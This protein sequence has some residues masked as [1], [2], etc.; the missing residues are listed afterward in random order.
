MGDRVIDNPIIN[1]PYEA[2][3]RYFDFDRD[4]IT[5]RVLDGR[6]PSSF[7]IP[8]PRP[9]KRGGQMELTVFTQDDITQNRQVNEV[10]LRDGCR[11]ASGRPAADPHGPDERG[12]RHGRHAA[13][14]DRHGQPLYGV[15]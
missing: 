9:R 14:E 2:P 15:R 11:A 13:Q 8:V 10:G 4:G 12:P 3:S 6:R 1:S 5:D 7:F